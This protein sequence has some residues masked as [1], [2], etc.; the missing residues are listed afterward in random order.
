[1]WRSF[2]MAVGLAAVI[3]GGELLAIEKATLTLPSKEPPQQHGF[4]NKIEQSFR[5]KDYV[6]PE[7]APW[8]FLSIGAVVF[9]YS[10]SAPK[11]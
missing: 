9:L 7:W 8:T 2:F 10:C 5:T 3:L 4:M 1:M 11:E 6:P